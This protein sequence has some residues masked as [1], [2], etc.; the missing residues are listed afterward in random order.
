VLASVTH[1]LPLTTV[2]RQRVLPAPGRVVVRVGQKVTATEVIAETALPR[3]HLLINV[4]HALGVSVEKAEKLIQC[5]KGDKI[6]KGTVIAETGGLI[7]RTVQAPHDGRVVVVGDGQ[8]MLEVGLNRIELKAGI[9]GEV[10]QV[11]PERGAIIHGSGALIQ[12]R[13]GNGRLDYGL[14]LS[15]AQAP[16]SVLDP[17][18]VDISMRGSVIL[19]GFC[20]DKKV[21]DNAAELPVRGLVLSSLA[22]ELIPTALQM[23]FPIVVLEGFGKYAFDAAAHRLL[24]TNVKREVAVNA[25]GADRY[26]GTRPEVMIPLPANQPPPIPPEAETLAEG[27][28]VRVTRAPWFGAVGSVAS[29]LPD[30]ARL[31]NGVMARSAAVKLQSGEQVTVP[32]VNLEVL[33]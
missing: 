9:P 1:I 7:P 26:S 24:T 18:S 3:E 2:V 25:E 14:L 11:I 19:G 17:A 21:L 13:W 8:V 28:Q 23:R 12:G 33:A 32:L 15:L 20:G 4:P 31:P 22:P 29:L 10:A 30:L 5:K 16:D 6:A 27:V